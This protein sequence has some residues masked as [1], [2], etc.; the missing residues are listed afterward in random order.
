MPEAMSH[1]HLPAKGDVCEGEESIAL[2]CAHRGSIRLA[3]AS[4]GLVIA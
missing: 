4:G 3:G 2:E 1:A